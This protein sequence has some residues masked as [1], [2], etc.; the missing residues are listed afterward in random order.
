MTNDS[1]RK[2]ENEKIAKEIIGKWGYEHQNWWAPIKEALD[3]KDSVISQ[4]DA[5]IERLKEDIL[6]G[7]TAQTTADITTKAIQEV[8]E[9]TLGGRV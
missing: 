6:I 9:R 8:M 4:K 1:S 5:E 3:A 7:K 2:K